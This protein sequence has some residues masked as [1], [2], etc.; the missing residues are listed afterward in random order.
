MCQMNVRHD[1]DSYSPT[2]EMTTV[3]V[4]T[5][6]WRSFGL[7]LVC[8]LIFDQLTLAQILV[9]WHLQILQEPNLTLG[10]VKN[11]H[12]NGWLV[13]SGKQACRILQSLN[14]FT[15][16]STT[17]LQ[18]WLGSLMMEWIQGECRFNKQNCSMVTFSYVQL[19]LFFTDFG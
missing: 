16:S 17:L 12:P 1:G 18:R 15:N 19:E 8:N 2:W 13:I 4:T 6:H 7:D 3:C 10:S 9:C 11:Y 5:L 14:H